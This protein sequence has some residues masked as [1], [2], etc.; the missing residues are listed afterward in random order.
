[1][2]SQTVLGPEHRISVEEALRAMTLE[3]AYQL[4]LNAEVG[5]IEFGEKKRISVFWM[6]IRW[7]S[8][9]KS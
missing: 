3:A 1:M 9:L 5:S 4:H 6:P 2:D 8:I 7:R